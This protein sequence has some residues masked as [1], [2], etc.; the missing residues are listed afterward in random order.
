MSFPCGFPVLPVPHQVQVIAY[1]VTRRYPRSWP[2]RSPCEL[3]VK[4][5]I[6]VIS[7]EQHGSVHSSSVQTCQLLNNITRPGLHSPSSLSIPSIARDCPGFGLCSATIAAA[8][9]KSVPSSTSLVWV[10]P[11]PFYFHNRIKALLCRNLFNMITVSCGTNYVP[12]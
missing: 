9:Q 4:L 6:Q 5:D 2:V 3:T 8:P 1:M 7:D 10:S 11:I 12:A